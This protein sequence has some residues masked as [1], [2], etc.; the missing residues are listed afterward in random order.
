[1]GY[2]KC[3]LEKPEEASRADCGD[4]YLPATFGSKDTLEVPEMAL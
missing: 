3:E 2:L 1:L 4:E